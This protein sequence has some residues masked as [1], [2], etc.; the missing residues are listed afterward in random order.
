[1]STIESSANF[2]KL[3]VEQVT[4]GM[5]VAELDRPW[6]DTPFLLEGLLIASTDEI[7]ALRRYCSFAYVDPSRS[8][9]QAA[10]RLRKRANKIRKADETARLDARSLGVDGERDSGARSGHPDDGDVLPSQTH[11]SLMTRLRG[12]LRQLGRQTTDVDVPV[13][14]GLLARKLEV[15]MT[16]RLQEYAPALPIEQE[17]PRARQTWAECEQMLREF[18]HDVQ[19]DAVLELEKVE[20]VAGGLVES[21]VSNP[22]AMMWVARLRAEHQNIYQHCLKV[23]LYLVAL[24]RHIGFPREDLVRLALIGMLADVG[25]IRLPASLLNKPG[26]LTGQEHDVVKQ[27]VELGIETLQASLKLDSGVEQAIRQ[28]HERMDGSGYPLGLKD[29]QIG[30]FGRMAGVADCFA[31]LIS[32]RPYARAQSPQEAMLNLYQWAGSSFH[33]PLVEQFVQAV[34][35]FP[36][37]SLVELSNEEVAI[38]L[39]HNRARRLAPRVLILSG[40]D[41]VQLDVP[42]ERNLL[43]APPGPGGEPLRIVRGLNAGAYG[44]DPG[45]YYADASASQ[46]ALGAP[47]Q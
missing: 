33:E 45:D 13:D 34:G 24:G 12:W 44:L 8:T 4:T 25:K 5:Y 2:L 3:P 38:V 28:H 15:P 7:D 35:V 19:A 40:A 18:S 26:V 1:M 41:K 36:V 20:A 22:D 14:R 32:A 9:P 27:H 21:M 47:A 30:I 16:V 37:G 43:R 11:A 31:A 10:E 23:A 46:D 6:L 42:F 39:S 17:L 29:R